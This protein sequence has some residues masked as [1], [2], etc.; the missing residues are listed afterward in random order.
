MGFVYRLRCPTCGFQSED[1]VI[2]LGAG[3]A[4]IHT[5]I[6]DK[7]TGQLR[8]LAVPHS[9]VSEHCG[10]FAPC[11][12]EDFV[13]ALESYIERQ[14]GANETAITPHEAICPGCRGKPCVESCGFT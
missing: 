12:E 9:A 5:L 6:Q 1:I 3:C 8:R 14:L 13:A 2:G 7:L 11:S 10:L 4:V